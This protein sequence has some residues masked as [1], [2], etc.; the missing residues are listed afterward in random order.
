MTTTRERSRPG[1]IDNFVAHLVGLAD[2]KRGDRA[3]LAVLRRGLG[4]GPDYPADLHRH[5]LPF[6]PKGREYDEEKT[7]LVASLFG[8]FPQNHG[9]SFARA[10]R[11]AAEK[12]N[13][14]IERRLMAV[15]N[16][17]SEDLGEHLRQLVALLR[18]HESPGFDWARFLDDLLRWQWDSRPAQRQW[19]RDFWG[20]RAGAVEPKTAAASPDAD[21]AT[22]EEE[23]IES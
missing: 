17:D 16:A 11:H 23:G 1:W 7:Y 3:A 15:L 2:E 6:M 5:V 10:L 13:P 9:Q 20:D 22:E 19:A 14:N 4:R 18:T 12:D 21:L 8:L